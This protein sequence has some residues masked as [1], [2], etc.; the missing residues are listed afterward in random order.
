MK[1]YQ[2]AQIGSDHISLNLAPF[3]AAP[4]IAGRAIRMVV[5]LGQLEVRITAIKPHFPS[6]QANFLISAQFALQFR[7]NIFEKNSGFYRRHSMNAIVPNSNHKLHCQMIPWPQK[8]CDWCNRSS[9]CSY[10][11]DSDWATTCADHSNPVRQ[12]E[13]NV[14]R[15]F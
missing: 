15:P 11:W 7:R 9:L 3:V 4:E 8:H 6:P 13:Y 5:F 14:K 2:E 10:R 1:I 12:T